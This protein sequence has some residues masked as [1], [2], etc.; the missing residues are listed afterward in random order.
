MIPIRELG[1]PAWPS[2]LSAVAFVQCLTPSLAQS[3]HMERGGSALE[4]KQD[5]IPRAGCV[6]LLCLSQVPE[7]N[8]ED[9]GAFMAPNLSWMYQCGCWRMK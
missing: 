5:V 9:Y 6:I 4:R 1:L 8:N 7:Q 2:H 3:G